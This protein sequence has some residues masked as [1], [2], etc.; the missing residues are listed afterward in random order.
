[1]KTNIALLTLLLAGLLLTACGKKKEEAKQVPFVK[2]TAALGLGDSDMLTFPGK[3]KSVEDVNVAFRVSGP[4]RKVYVK[5]GDY[6]R[7]GQL[8]AEMDPR[9]Y[10]VQLSATQAEY[11]QIKADAERVIALYN[12]GNTTASNYDKARYGLQQITEKLANHRNQ[13]ADTKLYAPISGYIQKRLHSDGE[14]ISAGMPVVSMFSSADTEIEIFVP[15]SDYAKRDQLVSAF[16]SFEV[17]PD[18]NFPLEISSYSKEANASQLYSV[19]FKIAGSYDRSKITPGMT[20]M[21]YVRYNANDADKTVKVPTSAVN[22]KEGK[23]VVFVCDEKAGVVHERTITVGKIDL[24]GNIEVKEG[25][26][27]GENVVTSGVRFLQDGQ[28]V[29]I[30]PPTSEANVGGLL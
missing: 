2:T 17:V 6:V 15:A 29:R 24:H 10:R 28:K 1:M 14:T 26:K 8:I 30:L 21:V 9:D 3:T 11:E 5:E 20:T 27:T 19:R 23:T 18:E 7:R 12:E 4:I 22:H 13:L 16:C 25:I